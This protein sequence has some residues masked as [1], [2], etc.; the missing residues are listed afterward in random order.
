[1]LAKREKKN[2]RHLRRSRCRLRNQHPFIVPPHAVLIH[3]SCFNPP[4]QQNQ[5]QQQHQY[6]LPVNVS[7]SK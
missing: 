5:P 4:K 7:Q 3:F 2:N 1:M 6:W